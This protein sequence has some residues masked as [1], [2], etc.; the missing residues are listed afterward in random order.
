MREKEKSDNA[1]RLMLIK[2]DIFLCLHWE[3]EWPNAT[4]VARIKLFILC[5]RF[6]L[7]TLFCID[8]KHW[9]FHEISL[10]VPSDG[11]RIWQMNK[12]NKTTQNAKT[13]DVAEIVSMNIFAHDHFNW[14]P[15][16]REI[17][18]EKLVVFFSFKIWCW[19]SFF[20][21]IQ[22][23]N[24]IFIPHFDRTIFKQFTLRA[25]SFHLHYTKLNSLEKS[26]MHHKSMYVWTHFVLMEIR[27]KD[28][29]R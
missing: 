27:L 14:M 4:R 19:I 17:H 7:L 20:I 15:F 8:F 23:F 16:D 9:Y 21:S 25:P 28:T 3:N 5:R 13:I 26:I 22:K 12:I 29:D 18:S 11:V 6:L 1:K 10:I 24:I 2:S